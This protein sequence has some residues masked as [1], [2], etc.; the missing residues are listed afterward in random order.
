MPH[1]TPVDQP[2]RWA[3]APPADG[4][5]VVHADEHIV[6]VDKPAGLLSV[7]GIAPEKA[8]CVRSRVQAM[9]PGATGP[10]TPHRL[11]LSTSGLM[12]LGL[13]ARTHR[14]LSIQFEQRRAVKTYVALID[15]EVAGSAG[16]IHV[17]MRKDLERPPMQ[18]IDYARGKAST[19]EWE[20][21]GHERWEGRAASRVRLMPV[22]GRTHQLRVHA[23][24]PA[25]RAVGTAGAG[26]EPGFGSAIIGD[27]LY[28]GYPAPRLMLH[29]WTLTI[30]HPFTGRR[31]SFKAPAPF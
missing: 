17:P 10:L 13:D 5:A 3:Y 19:T 1:G 8:D 22:T 18:I 24:H 12:V 2:P 4:P 16:R 30:H 20:L 7:P 11:D 14:N 23:A 15:G 21:L 9:F 26:V 29:A 28:G 31:M 6:V 25:M 27:E